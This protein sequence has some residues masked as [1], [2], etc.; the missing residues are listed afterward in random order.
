MEL[1]HIIHLLQLAFLSCIMHWICLIGKQH[2]RLFPQGAAKPTT[3][4]WLTIFMIML[5][6][7]NQWGTRAFHYT[8]LFWS[9][10]EGQSTKVQHDEE[11][12]QCEGLRVSPFNVRLRVSVI[13][14]RDCECSKREQ[15][16][17]IRNAVQICL[18]K[19]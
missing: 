6:Q 1:P 18:Y 4:Q 7:Y 17:S 5:R 15:V 8:G 2:F 11:F 12:M 14:G 13:S 19:P 3:C 16:C 10:R 9:L